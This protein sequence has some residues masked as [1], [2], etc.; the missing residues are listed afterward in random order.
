L[1]DYSDDRGRTLAIA[2][3]IA[4]CYLYL[5]WASFYDGEQDKSIYWEH[6]EETLALHP[7][8]LGQLLA[9]EDDIEDEGWRGIG[10]DEALTNNAL[11]RL[12]ENERETIAP[13]LIQAWGGVAGLHQALRATMCSGQQEPSVPVQTAPDPPPTSAQP[14]PQLQLD[15]DADEE[16]E[17]EGE[18]EEEEDDFEATADNVQAYAWIQ[19]GCPVMA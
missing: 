19:D 7:F 14:S 9:E 17:E 16:D 15:F 6:E 3:F 10:D 12:A 11:K 18:Y 8:Y 2:R 1:A 4:L 5:D 13:V